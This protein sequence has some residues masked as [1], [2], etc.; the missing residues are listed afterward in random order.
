MLHWQH[1]GPAVD[2][3]AGSPAA[4][5]AVDADV[6]AAAAVLLS[7]RSLHFLKGE[8]TEYPHLE[9]PLEVCEE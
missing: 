5:D 1:A 4:V 3:V 7:F 6:V 2:V 8:E 9:E